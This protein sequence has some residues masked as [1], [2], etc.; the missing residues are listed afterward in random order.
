MPLRVDLD[1]LFTEAEHIVPKVPR[2]TGTWVPLAGERKPGLELRLNLHR[3]ALSIRMNGSKLTMRT[4]V[5]YG[6]EVGLPVPGRGVKPVAACG[7]GKEGLRQVILGAEAEVAFTPDWDLEVRNSV[8]PALGVNPCKFESIDLTPEVARG[9]EDELTRAIQGLG[10]QIRTAALLRQKVE[11]AWRLL[12]RPI[13]LAPGLHL[14]MNPEGI[15]L[16]PLVTEGRTL[17]ILPEISARPRLTFGARPPVSQGPLPA[18]NVSSPPLPQGFQIQITADLSFEEATL[19]IARR[20][21]GKDLRTEKGRMEITGAKVRG[22][23]GRALLEVDV[24]GRFKGR[25]TL[26][27]RPRVDVAANTLRLQD[28]EYT[29]EPRDWIAKKGEWVLRSSLRQMLQEHAG[30]FMAQSLGDARDQVNLRLNRALVPGLHLRGELEAL[31]PEQ[32]LVLAD[33]FRVAATL[34]GSLEATLVD[35]SQMY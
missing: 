25:L 4:L 1:P 33:R 14:S 16:A 28:L 17:I 20:L 10:Q 23:A 8:L 24:K 34:Q 18:L 13:E 15:H 26:A 21:V 5:H 12:G 35:P 22:D 3:E 11:T 31:N 19:Q 7:Q 9:T 29:L 32:P 6:L 30:F 27:G 2:G